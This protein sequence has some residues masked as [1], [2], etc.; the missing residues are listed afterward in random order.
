M[1]NITKKSANRVDIELSGSLDADSMR[2]ALDQLIEVSEG[3]SNGHMLYRISDF[4]MPTLGAIGVEMARLPKLFGLL[5][6]FDKCAVLSD[7]NWLRTAATVEGALFPGI[8]IKS[9]EFDE[10]D[11]AEAWLGTAA[12]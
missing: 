4:S 1:L 7:S 12:A 9:F 6:K 8:D 5:G 2:I 11:A 10:I 3:V